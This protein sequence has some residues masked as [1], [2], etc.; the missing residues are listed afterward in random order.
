MPMSDKMKKQKTFST[1]ECP[2]L[3][4]LLVLEIQKEYKSTLPLT[5]YTR[6]FLW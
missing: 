6:N 1:V 4:S 5:Q 2:C 3:G